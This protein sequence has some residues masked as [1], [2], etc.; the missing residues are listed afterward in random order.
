MILS[1]QQLDHE[2]NKYH[3]TINGFSEQIFNKVREAFENNFKLGLEC[4]S[5]LCIYHKGK[6][7]VDLSGVIDSDT[8]PGGMKSFNDTDIMANM[9]E[10]NQDS[11][12]QIFSSTKNL[13]ALCINMCVDRGLLDYNE[14]VSKYWQEFGKNGKEDITLADVLRH[15]SGLFRFSK[16][17][18]NEFINDQKP[19]GL[20]SKLIEDSYPIWDISGVTKK[21]TKTRNYHA[22]TRGLILQQ[23]IQRVDPKGRTINDFFR[24]EVA[25]PLNISDSTFISL[26][27]NKEKSHHIAPMI[28]Y[29]NDIP[30]IELMLQVLGQKINEQDLPWSL[31]DPDSDI[32]DIGQIIDNISVIP[33]IMLN[34]TAAFIGNLNSELSYS[35]DSPSSNGFSNA[36]GLGK[37][38]GLLANKGELDGVRL[39]SN[40]GFERSHKGITKKYDQILLK[41]NSF[42]QGG[43]G[44]FLNNNRSE[45]DNNILFLVNNCG[46]KGDFFGWGGAGGSVFIWSTDLNIGLSY[47]MNGMTNYHSGNPRTRRILNSLFESLSDINKTN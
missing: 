4:G 7:V 6:C 11:L 17:A 41:Y 21:D 5:Q 8:T 38:A 24:D 25:E 10:Y 35:I 37:I 46:I 18:D 29:I 45:E 9:K 2:N 15:D 34:T 31:K 44:Y 22:I 1:E 12:Q 39:I 36:R 27:R 47:T 30:D 19:S 28:N 40:L 33:H 43:F 42:T 23:I 32:Y 3:Y 26:S 16:F 20:M 13:T 14:R